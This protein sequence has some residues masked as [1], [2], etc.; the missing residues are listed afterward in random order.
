MQLLPRI[1]TEHRWERNGA[2]RRVRRCRGRKPCP[3]SSASPSDTPDPTADQHFPR[4]TLGPGS[5]EQSCSQQVPR[6]RHFGEL[7]VHILPVQEGPRDCAWE[8]QTRAERGQF[9]FTTHREPS[10]GA[11]LK[12]CLKA[13]LR[14]QAFVAVSLLCTDVSSR[15]VVAVTAVAALPLRG[16]AVCIPSHL[17]TLPRGSPWLEAGGRS[18]P[19]A[20]ARRGHGTRRVISTTWKLSEERVLVRG[21]GCKK[22]SPK[23]QT[24]R[25]TD[26]SRSLL[27]VCRLDVQAGCPPGGFWWGLCRAFSLGPSMA[28]GE[29]GLLGVPL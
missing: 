10:F 14:P 19:K 20:A 15:P 24:G 28:D 8:S 11:I 29:R 6:I 9:D 18:A 5:L 22:N 23:G 13:P 4:T 1:R 3:V 17:R 2:G 25:P 16:P 21:G 12:A 26:R 7:T 27:T